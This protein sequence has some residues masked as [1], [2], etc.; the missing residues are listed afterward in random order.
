[1]LLGRLTALLSNANL[2]EWLSIARFEYYQSGVLPTNQKGVQ[3]F[4][5]PN[6]ASSQFDKYS[7]LYSRSKRSPN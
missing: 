1:M 4:W 3:A 6:I 5:T 7:E 2:H